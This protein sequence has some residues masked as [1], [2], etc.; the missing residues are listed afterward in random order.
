MSSLKIS[1]EIVSDFIKFGK[2]MTAT[3]FKRSNANQYLAPLAKQG[4]LQS[5]WHTND[6]GTKCKMYRINDMKKALK[7]LGRTA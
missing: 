3:D 4:I 1:K 6:K 7:F 5:R 2:E